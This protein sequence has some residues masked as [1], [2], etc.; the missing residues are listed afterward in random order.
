MTPSRTV[1]NTPE[2]LPESLVDDPPASNATVKSR[3]LRDNTSLFPLLKQVSRSFYLT[4]RVLPSQVRSQIGLAYLLARATDTVADTRIVPVESRLATLS[5]LRV[6]ILGQTGEP[7]SFSP[8]LEN[9]ADSAA[10][11]AERLLLQRIEEF[12]ACLRTVSDADRQLI[13]AVLSTIIS[14]QELDLRRFGH[15]EP[16]Q[17][18]ALANEQEL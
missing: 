11:P 3:A 12:L 4:L 5:A 8:F 15:T 7:L 13:R 17:I 14:G 6:R 1:A 2:H 9:T 18:V 10:L 16:N